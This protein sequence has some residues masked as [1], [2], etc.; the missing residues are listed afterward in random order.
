MYNEEQ[1]ASYN[2]TQALMDKYRPFLAD[3]VERHC[4]AVKRTSKA[5]YYICPLCGHDDFNL[6]HSKPGFWYCYYPGHEKRK[7]KNQY[8]GFGGDIFDLVGAIEGLDTKRDFIKIIE[9]LKNEFGDD[10]P[11][12]K[13]QP[14]A[15]KKQ[16]RDNTGFYRK[17]AAA[18]PVFLAGKTEYRGI[19]LDTLKHFCIGYD[20]T[21]GGG[22]VVPSDRYSYSK[23][24]IDETQH[25]GARYY[26]T[27]GA[28][29]TPFNHKAFFSDVVSSDVSGL[30]VEGEFDCMSVYE[31][32]SHIPCIATRSNDQALIKGLEALP[33]KPKRP[34]VICMDKDDAGEG[35]TRAIKEGLEALGIKYYVYQWE[36]VPYKD[37]NDFL[38]AD[39]ECFAMTIYSLATFNQ[40]KGRDNMETTTQPTT[41]EEIQENLQPPTEK[42]GGG[43]FLRYRADMTA[44]QMLEDIQ[45]GIKKAVYPTGFKQLDKY[46]GGGL[47]GGLYVIG[48]D[49][50]IGKTSFC[51]QMADQIA[52]K[53]PVLF[54][55]YEMTKQQ[56][57]AK[58]LSRFCYKANSKFKLSC[59]DLQGYGDG[60]PSD[61]DKA[62][63]ETAVNEYTNGIA[64][65]IYII[66]ANQT[67]EKIGEK[68]DKFIQE[69]GA[70]P[71]VVVDYLQIVPTTGGLMTAGATERTADTVNKL[72]A[73]YRKYNT[74]IILVS[75]WSRN[76]ASKNSMGA[77]RDSSTIEYNATV[78]LGME[79]E[80]TG[81]DGEPYIDGKGRHIILTILKNKQAVSNKKIKMI[82]HEASQTF[83]E[84]E[85][86]PG[87]TIK[88][89]E[90]KAIKENF[91][92]E[93][94]KII[95]RK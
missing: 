41:S 26:K 10:E 33:N 29:A 93:H 42:N 31:I 76:K 40:E 17:W 80:T 7:G 88:G 9:I 52:E 34:L 60:Q 15:E 25:G 49:P 5:S 87:A 48:A 21:M 39:R 11:I 47:M 19:S 27:A 82:L 50:G 56:L 30:I 53:R 59:L 24:W 62:T 70:V 44:A 3:Y 12:N 32:D 20:D 2:N 66:E 18:L 46:L 92:D 81:A 79:N 83:K 84:S 37:F 61:K 65:N 13:P 85:E 6:P 28:T 57:I 54:F 1:Q 69:T 23:R 89:K 63:L 95:R 75:A 68:L 74:P 72:T 86:I 43:D 94:P 73:L 38:Q 51:L 71:V 67:A 78:C 64:K 90:A 58:S 55:S 16:P 36:N 8:V 22:I 14:P 91:D 35:H 45:K 77:Y 4:R